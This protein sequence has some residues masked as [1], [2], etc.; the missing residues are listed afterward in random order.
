MD[1]ALGRPLR[2]SGIRQEEGLTVPGGDGW[3]G[4]L[5]GSLCLPLGK[6]LKGPA[7]AGGLDSG[8]ELWE[9]GHGCR[10]G[11]GQVAGRPTSTP[12]EAW[13]KL[14]P[15]LSSFGLAAGD[16]CK[17]GKPLCGGQHGGWRGGTPTCNVH[18]G[19]VPLTLV[20]RAS[21]SFRG[22]TGGFFL[23]CLG[24]GSDEWRQQAR[25]FWP[26]H[27]PG[28]TLWGSQ[29]GGRRMS[30]RVALVLWV[31]AVWLEG[32]RD[33]PVHLPAGPVRQLPAAE[34]AGL[35]PGCR[36]HCPRLAGLRR[37]AGPGCPP[38]PELPADALPALPAPGLPP[39]LCFQSRAT[40]RLPQ[41]PA[42]GTACALPGA[43]V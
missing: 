12:R 30:P 6:Y 1:P 3:R 36:V 31:G 8:C 19:S 13:C 38:R 17:S 35:Q 25:P 29:A 20:D 10:W 33:W 26:P 2:G 41:Q 28:A 43:R 34:A 5:V 18:G 16:P 42:G 11:G 23:T 40:D 9:R 22:V 27:G 14:P 39:A 32:L 15:W 7:V 4:Y 21:L 24:S 37:P